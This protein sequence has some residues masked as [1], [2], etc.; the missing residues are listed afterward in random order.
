MALR[1]TS[2]KFDPG[3]MIP[4]KYTCDGLDV[5][6]PLAWTEGVPG[7][8]RS[9]ALIVD[10]PDA[11]SGTFTHWVLFNLPAQATGL[12]E[13]VPR[14]PTLSN[15]ARQGTN[16]FRRIGY[17][18][19]CPPSGQ[20]RYFFKLYALYAALDLRD[21]AAKDELTEAMRGHV[22]AEAE[23]MGRYARG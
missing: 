19:P 9:F 21:G 6:P 14:E 1:V 23:L 12:P 16:G 22:L 8:T 11:P 13:N 10:D 15:G 18:G 7:G 2:A 3:G 5:S 17:G 4:A 20:H